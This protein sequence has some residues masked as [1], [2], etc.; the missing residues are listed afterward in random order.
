MCRSAAANAGA[1]AGLLD[2]RSRAIHSRPEGSV[3]KTRITCGYFSDPRRVIDDEALLAI[4]SWCQCREWTKRFVLH[5]PYAGE[6][7]RE[8]CAAPAR[9]IRKHGI[10]VCSHSLFG[11]K[12]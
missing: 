1:L 5:Q 9:R 3:G 8:G 4:N 12:V 11:E 7:A 6:S 2:E 10:S